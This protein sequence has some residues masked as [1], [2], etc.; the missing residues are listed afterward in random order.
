MLKLSDRKIAY[1]FLAAFGGYIL[2]W[3]RVYF[4]DQNI[5][6][7]DLP[8]HV[9]L[10]RHLKQQLLS[11]HI[12]FYDKDTFTGFPAFRFYGFVPALLTAVLAFPLEYLGF[13]GVQL[14]SH[15]ILVFGCAVLPFSFFW[16]ARVY[17]YEL[18]GDRLSE[19]ALA[20]LV[21]AYS[22]WFL[23]HDHQ[24][25]GIGAAAPMN[26]GLFAQLFG[27]HLLLLYV[28]ALGRVLRV[29]GA[30]SGRLLALV[31]AFLPLTHT[32]SFVYASFLAA[33]FFLLY[34]AYRRALF[35]FHV[36][37]F[38]LA[39]FWFLPALS[40][41]GAYSAYDVSRPTG[42]FLEILFR[43]PWYGLTRSLHELI[44]E[45]GYW[46]DPIHIFLP[47]SL[48]LVCAHPAV[49]RDGIVFGLWVSV[50]VGIIFFGSGFIA[51][52]LP[53]GLHYY[54]FFAFHFLLFTLLA[55][56]APFAFFGSRFSSRISTA[57]LLLFAV[58]SLLATSKLP[59]KE[60][61]MIFAHRGL[62]Y[63]S[64][65]RQ[66][67]E[68]F[69][70]LPEKGRVYI[71]YLKDYKRFPQLSAHYLSSRLPFE[72]GFE[73]IVNSHLQESMAYRMIAGTANMLGA[74]TYHVPLLFP[75][76]S[77]V[78][79]EDL[80]QQ[81]RDFGI[82]HYI[83]ARK[84]SCAKI[85]EVLKQS[86]IRIG[87]YRIFDLVP[88]S[89]SLVT[90]AQKQLVG[91]LDLSGTLPFYLLQYYVYARSDLYPH[92]EIIALEPKDSVP[93][94][95]SALLVN[96]SD[97]AAINKLAL[98]QSLVVPLHY[99][100]PNYKL[101]HYDV[102]YPHNLEFDRYREIE[103]YLD[104]LDLAA[105]LAPKMS[106]N[107]EGDAS[108]SV[109]PKMTWS[110]DAQS[111]QLSQLKPNSFYRVNYSYFP[112]WSSKNARV[113]RG[114]GER[115]FVLPQEEQ[116]TFSY[117]AWKHP[118]SWLGLFISFAALVILILLKDKAKSRP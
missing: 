47:L 62:E 5:A 101:N 49:K 30:S 64:Q 18:A 90:P 91:Y 43:Y 87:R 99:K 13:D 2:W 80:V 48:L 3:F 9:A 22:F 41:L 25:F 106:K 67:V 53:L 55:A 98:N 34:S 75:E 66:V 88:G 56:V 45:S 44:F 111:F 19:T 110:E 109:Q 21:C 93:P 16:A 59:H 29:G 8:S 54:R 4:T 77:D 37:G 113:F 17:A 27:W 26:I 78:S 58:I 42:D 114:S 104:T 61:E 31:Y 79:D 20:A 96:S 76:H 72:T 15:L 60:R 95:L 82:T 112:Y 118:A 103:N 32:L 83:C 94:G 52:S 33:F 63:L 14:A 40:L 92:I 10:V 73:S 35:G 69:R 12:T 86:P 74:S 116:V 97:A 24:W 89:R 50:L 1:L 107:A 57:A 23:N 81:L 46:L 28:G 39:A 102:H 85:Q 117:S 71:E 68:H 100:R 11:G 51:S 108:Y 6:S 70:A 105:I 38:G 7:V 84:K 65:E 36:L 115:M